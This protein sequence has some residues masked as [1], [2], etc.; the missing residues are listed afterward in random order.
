[1]RVNEWMSSVL[2][3]WHSSVGFR[4]ITNGR[5]AGRRENKFYYVA[6]N[7]LQ[8]LCVIG[9]NT[10]HWMFKFFQERMGVGKEWLG[11]GSCWIDGTLL[12]SIT[13]SVRVYL[14]QAPSQLQAIQDCEECDQF[15]KDFYLYTFISEHPPCGPSCFSARCCC[16]GGFMLYFVP[17]SSCTE[18]VREHTICQC[19]LEN[20]WRCTASPHRPEAIT[21]IG[22]RW[23]GTEG[24]A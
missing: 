9:F 18:I 20:P 12:D 7:T 15:I 16:S 11:V 4:R 19:E 5:R 22:S 10:K 17:F 21:R 14:V 24:D 23:I 8:G 2:K 3:S 6:S 1:M 13:P